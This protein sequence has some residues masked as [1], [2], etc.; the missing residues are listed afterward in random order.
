MIT[1]EKMET[2]ESI[3]SSG[4]TNMFDVKAVIF[5]SEDILTKE[6]CIEIMKNYKSLMEKFGIERR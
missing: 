5:L 2:Y 4:I 3:R 6:D 1:K